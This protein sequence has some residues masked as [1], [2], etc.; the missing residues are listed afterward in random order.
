[1]LLQQSGR[2]CLVFLLDLNRAAWRAYGQP[3]PYT[4]IR[5]DGRN[6]IIETKASDSLQEL[7]AVT[8]AM[9]SRAIEDWC[10]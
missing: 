5:I 8:G 6:R 9:G 10:Y 4:A 2:G 7:V 3:A 1:M